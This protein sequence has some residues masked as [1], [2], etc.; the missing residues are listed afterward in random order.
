MKTNL[1]FIV[2]LVFAFQVKAQDPKTKIKQLSEDI[3][4]IVKIQ[5]AQLTQTLEDVEKRLEKREIT[6]EQAKAFKKEAADTT[7]NT[8]EK[9]TSEKANLIAD[10]TKELIQISLQD[11]LT[12]RENDST[13]QRFK[14][15]F[16][17]NKNQVYKRTTEQVIIGFGLNNVLIN[18]ELS[19]LDN[20]PYAIWNSNFLE[21][22]YNFKTAFSKTSS[23]WN[24]RYGASFTWNEL[25]LFDNQYHIDNNGQTQIATHSESLKKSKLR[26]TQ[27][28]VPVNLEWDFSKKMTKNDKTF[29]PRDQ[30]MKIGLGA[31]GGLRLNTKQ[32]LKFNAPRDSKKEKLNNDYNM[33]NLI[34]G[35]MGYVGY[36]DTS[37][38]VKYDLNPLFK[39]T[40]TRNLSLGIRWDL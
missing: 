5:K 3:E 31:Y 22:G 24:I 1:F 11:S 19:S 21:L 17:R 36:R 28:I 40:E 33:N 10:Y 13:K 18:N 20:S 25:K 37:L 26:Q 14:I 32:I 7:A 9:L 39:D 34:Y 16:I 27:L 29:Y 15:E 38:Y 35:L 8:I 2:V 6:E 12:V 30:A 4:T 23:L